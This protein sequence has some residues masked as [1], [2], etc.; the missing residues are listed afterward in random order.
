MKKLS[1]FAGYA[2][3]VALLALAGCGGGGGG[4]DAASAGSNGGTGAGGSQSQSSNEVPDSAAL[5]SSAFIAFL[6]TMVLDDETS[7]PMTIR[8]GWA[9]PANEAGDPEPMG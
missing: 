2:T 5:S 9:V 6:K 7:E 8:E 1:K 3:L 4:N